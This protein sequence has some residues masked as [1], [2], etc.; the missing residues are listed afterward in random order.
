MQTPLKIQRTSRADLLDDAY[1]E[2]IETCW[3]LVTHLASTAPEDVDTMF[4][5]G[6]STPFLACLLRL[7]RGSTRLYARGDNSVGQLGVSLTSQTEYH[8]SPE[9]LGDPALKA[10]HATDKPTKII[11][12]VLMK[13]PASFP[14][15]GLRVTALACGEMHVVALLSD[16]RPWG[17]G[18][19]CTAQLGWGGVAALYNKSV[20]HPI[21]LYNPDLALHCKKDPEHNNRNMGLVTQKVTKIACGGFFTLMIL[22]DGRL[23]SLGTVHQTAQQMAFGLEAIVPLPKECGFVTHIACGHAFAIASTTENHVMYWGEF[24]MKLG[25]TT[26]AAPS[27][28]PELIEVASI[29]PD[30]FKKAAITDLQAG[31]SNALILYDDCHIVC[32]GDN[33]KGQLGLGDCRPRPT[34]VNNDTFSRTPGTTVRPVCGASHTLALCTVGEVT[35]LIGWGSNEFNQFG[36]KYSAAITRPSRL[37]PSVSPRTR[38]FTSAHTFTSALLTGDGL[39][40]VGGN[41]PQNFLGTRPQATAG[42]VHTGA[43]VKFNN[44]LVGSTFIIYASA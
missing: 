3:H 20:G 4:R 29:L 40:V 19:N 37:Q 10:Y 21:P 2:D 36:S 34:P 7:I 35:S 1:S 12:N 18:S 41:N 25:G 31:Y 9:I 38:I 6:N 32:W 28:Y 13:I 44:V 33:D 26:I 5:L 15:A 24:S 27:F 11:P 43:N 8:D 17:W 39:L 42:W 14:P 22:E 16:G 23:A 30:R